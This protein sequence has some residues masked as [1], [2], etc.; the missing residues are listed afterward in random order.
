MG[1]MNDFAALAVSIVGWVGAAAS[2]G[3]YA[4]VTQRRIEPDSLLFQGLNIGGA[5]ALA[6]SASVNAAWPSA[7]ANVVWVAIGVQGL[8]SVKR[9]VITRRARAAASRLARDLRH[10]VG[11]HRPVRRPAGPEGP[12][13]SRRPAAAPRSGRSRRPGGR[14]TVGTREVRATETGLRAAG[15]PGLTEKLV[16]V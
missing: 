12:A 15:T 9:A 1:I 6:V 4:M 5:T 8:L 13:A 7:V 2:L 10:P 11:L 16:R 14:T 3:A